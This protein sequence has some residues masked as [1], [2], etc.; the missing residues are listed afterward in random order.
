MGLL[1][2]RTKYYGE[3]E[4]R[5]NKLIEEI[6]Q[7]HEINLFIDEVHT[8]IRAGV[9]KGAI[10]AINIRKLAIAGGELQVI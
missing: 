7:S 5:Q 2:A 1:V 3:F 10:D 6:K 8:L 9:A 4:E